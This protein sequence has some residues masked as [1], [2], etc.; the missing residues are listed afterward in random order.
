MAS[1]FAHL[2]EK[3][4]NTLEDVVEMLL[5][6]YYL[7]DIISATAQNTKWYLLCSV[8]LTFNSLIDSL[9]Y[10]AQLYSLALRF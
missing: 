6:K 3:I 8:R 2:H 7:P 1:A 4:C 9:S 10:E 5:L